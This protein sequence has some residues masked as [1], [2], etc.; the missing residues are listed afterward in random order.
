MP[1]PLDQPNRVRYDDDDDDDGRVPAAV[2]LSLFI[3]FA[4]TPI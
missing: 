1:H 2:S 3:S 4:A